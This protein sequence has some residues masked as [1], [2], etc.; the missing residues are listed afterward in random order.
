[1]CSSDL[2]YFIITKEHNYTLISKLSQYTIQLVFTTPGLII[3]IERF[4]PTIK[5]SNILALLPRSCILAQV[6]IFLQSFKG[7]AGRQRAKSVR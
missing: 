2:V 3:N 7:I 5:P 6:K 1:M 4:N